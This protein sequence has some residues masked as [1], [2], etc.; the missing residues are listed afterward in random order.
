MFFGSQVAEERS[1][2]AIACGI[3]RISESTLKD[4]CHHL[5]AVI[6]YACKV[7]FGSIRFM[8]SSA[9]LLAQVS[10]L[11]TLLHFKSNSLNV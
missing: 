8:I 9:I 4:I 6:A 5:H 10:S 3:L 2:I 11:S 7:S 1:S